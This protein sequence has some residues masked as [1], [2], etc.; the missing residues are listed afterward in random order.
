[1]GSQTHAPNTAG[2]WFPKVWKLL[3]KTYKSAVKAFHTHYYPQCEPGMTHDGIFSADPIRKYVQG[4]RTWIDK[5]G[6]DFRRELWITEIGLVMN[7][8]VRTDPRV[9]LYPLVVQDAM[10]GNV[11]RWAWYSENTS[12]GYATLCE[13][14]SPKQTSLG[15]VFAAMQSGV[16]PLK[17]KV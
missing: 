6:K 2:A 1:M 7:E 14:Y 4:V 13:P 16:Y 17:Q 11:E 8:D 10:N 15:N 3:P 9:T 12:D 5:I